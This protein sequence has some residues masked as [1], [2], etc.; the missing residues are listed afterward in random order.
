[1]E[2]EKFLMI[3]DG[4]SNETFHKKGERKDR[5]NLLVHITAMSK[6]RSDVQ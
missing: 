2:V 1:M 5:V 4:R 3:E 6:S